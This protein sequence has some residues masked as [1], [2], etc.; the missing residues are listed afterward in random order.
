MFISRSVGE[1]REGVY[2]LVIDGALTKL[3][4]GPLQNRRHAEASSQEKNRI[5][6]KAQT[7]HVQE[8]MG[9]VGFVGLDVI[10]VVI[11]NYG[12]KVRAN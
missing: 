11:V 7:I 5:D 4:H 6:S 8:W 2:D 3:I 1:C 9:W 10:V 12:D